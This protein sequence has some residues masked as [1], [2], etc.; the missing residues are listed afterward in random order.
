MRKIQ[1]SWKIWTILS[2]LV[3]VMA[4]GLV[5]Y[6]ASLSTSNPFSS[7]KSSNIWNTLTATG[8]DVLMDKLEWLDT[9]V[10]WLN[11]TVNWL[12]SIPDWAIMAFNLTSCPIWWSP[13]YVADWRFLMWWKTESSDETWWDDDNK[14]TL[15]AWQIPQ[16]SHIFADTIFS[17]AW[18]ESAYAS[19]NTYLKDY[20]VVEKYKADPRYGDS[21]MVW[22]HGESIDTDNYLWAWLRKT[23]ASIC[24]DEGVTIDGDLSTPIKWE[25]VKKL[26]RLW[27]DS[28]YTTTMA[29]NNCNSGD[30]STVNIANAYVK[31]LYCVKWAAEKV[32]VHVNC[33]TWGHIVWTNM[34]GADYKVVKWAPITISVEEGKISI[35]NKDIRVAWDRNSGYEFAGATY[36]WQCGRNWVYTAQEE[37]VV[38]ANF[39]KTS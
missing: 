35:W 24:T 10:Q 17:E 12:D 11:S 19:N 29:E 6:A 1:Q 5:V 20:I 18:D 37:C 13:Y 9:N 32:K 8:W 33:G 4:C 25:N 28:R 22:K 21:Y 15:N 38:S 2:A 36:T 16:H 30:P 34:Q 31:V 14:I 27:V 26:Q 3:F 23:S 39:K 7:W